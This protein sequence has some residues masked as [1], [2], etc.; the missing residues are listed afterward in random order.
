MATTTAYRE[1]VLRIR[2]GGVGLAT[3]H[4]T[5]LVTITGPDAFTFMQARTSN[6]VMK[7][8]DGQGQ[9]SNVL[10]RGAHIQGHFTLHRLGDTLWLVTEK[11]QVPPALAQMK[12]YHILEQVNFEELTDTRTILTC[13]GIAA[14]ELLAAGTPDGKLIMEM[15]EHDI[16]PLQLFDQ[17]VILIR[18]TLTGETGFLILAAPGDT[19][20]IS[21]SLREAA[22]R[23]GISLVDMTPNA[24][25]ALRV[26]AGI[27]RF[28]NDYDTETLLPETGLEQVSVS[29]T[30]G[31]YLGQETV[32]RVKTYGSVQKAL[33]GLMFQPGVSLPSADSSILLNGKPI[34]TVKSGVESPTLM[35]PIALA[36]LGREHRTPGR[37]LTVHIQNPETGQMPVY[38]VTVTLLPFYTS[39]RQQEKA[40]KLL[41]TGLRAFAEGRDDEAII[42]LRRALALDQSFAD[43]YEALGVILSRRDEYEEA[44]GLMHKLVEMDPDRIMAHTNLSVFYMKMG[45]KERAE[46][47]KAKATVLGM[48]KAAAEKG[49]SFDAE[50]E[51]KKKEEATRQR[52]QMFQDAL[53]YNPDDP[54]GNFGLG[55]ACLELGQYD[56][57][58]AAL[59]K[60]VTAQRTHSAGWL[61]LAKAYE[62]AG[63][64]DK[65]IATYEE[66][67]E[68]ASQRRDLMPLKEMQT[69]LGILKDA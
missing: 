63:R 29:Y 14:D 60:T 42:N 67:I 61:A 40:R 52:I 27:P 68:V 10:D 57:A 9:A 30:K 2:E 55:S 19:K 23:Q 18:K 7:L 32:A 25:E 22:I 35:R 12:K 66:G 50:G 53:K 65:A 11:A 49:L 51:R 41:D 21:E 1:A 13:Q 28:G 36:Y 58:I 39:H 62:G 5:G 44:I 20:D 24:L 8:A 45:D 59:L 17:D 46:E 4:D 56:E 31:C 6:D 43:A 34:G 54:L 26:E 47:E 69:R 15:T 37:L 38:D 3:L 64:R 48:K 33:V 16:R